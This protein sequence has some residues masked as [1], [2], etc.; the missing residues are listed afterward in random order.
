MFAGCDEEKSAI[1]FSTTPFSKDYGYTP[2]N[3]FKKGERIHYLLYK[4]DEFKTRLIKVQ[5]FRKDADADEFW[6]YE[7]LYNKTVELQNKKLYTDYFIIN[8]TGYYIFQIFEFTNTLKP[9]I[10]G[11]V[12]V[13]D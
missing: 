3:T 13:I 1:L 12:K 11:V 8:K 2:Q 10:K 9:V 5:V 7:Y 6:G 4:P